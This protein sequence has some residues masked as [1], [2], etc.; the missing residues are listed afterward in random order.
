M[1]RDFEVTERA[2]CFTAFR[3]IVS[4]GLPC[5]S[6]SKTDKIAEISE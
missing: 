5:F 3:L 4:R 2:I 6:H 1:L